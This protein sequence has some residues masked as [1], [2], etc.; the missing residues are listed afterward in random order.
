MARRRLARQVAD[1]LNNMRYRGAT[2]NDLDR[3]AMFYLTSRGV[4]PAEARA[5]LVEAFVGEVTD[6]VPEG[7]VRDHMFAAI[8][9]WMAGT[10]REGGK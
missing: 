9:D 10:T 7:A 6:S 4:P 8:S 5:L 1:I 3:N 2:I